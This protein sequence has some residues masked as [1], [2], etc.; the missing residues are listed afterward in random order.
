MNNIATTI[1]FQKQVV[2]DE[3]IVPRD[4]FGM[5][6][7]YDFGDND[8]GDWVESAVGQ[9]PIDLCQVHNS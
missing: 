7:Y 4:L 1:L 5:A 8:L 6:L 9:I 3:Y 2:K